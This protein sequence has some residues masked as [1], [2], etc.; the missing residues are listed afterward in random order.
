MTRY[1]WCLKVKER[2]GNRCVICGAPGVHAHHIE[3]W[4]NKPDNGVTLCKRCH[5]LAHRG[6]FCTTSPG[7]LSPYAAAVK[8]AERARSNA[9]DRLI[10]RMVTAD[11]AKTKATHEAM[12]RLQTAVPFD[13][14]CPW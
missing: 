12:N 3:D 10:W 2:D 8:L 9:T 13:P 4:R 7:K 5:V 1:D 14:S 6:T 11:E